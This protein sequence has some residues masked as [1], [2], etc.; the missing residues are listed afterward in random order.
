MRTRGL[1]E[2]I[3]DHVHRHKSWSIYFPEQDRGASTPAWLS[4]WK[5]DGIIARIEIAEVAQLVR[6]TR[7]TAVDVS[8]LSGSWEFLG[9]IRMMNPSH[10]RQPTI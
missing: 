9:S 4:R 2:A 5:G 6:R 8:A 1:L 3:I 10:R 7:L